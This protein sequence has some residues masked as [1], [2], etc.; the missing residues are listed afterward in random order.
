[1]RQALRAACIVAIVLASG[2][3]RAQLSGSHIKG[4]FG[5]ASGT[6]APEGLLLVPFV[7]DYYTSTVVGMNGNSFSIQGSLDVLAAPGL[8]LWYVSP[9]KVLGANYGAQLSAAFVA[10]SIDLPRVNA[11]TSHYGFG[12]MFLKPVELGWHEKYFDAITGFGIYLPTGSYTPLANNNTGLGQWG[13][14]FQAGGTVW[15]DEGRHFNLA[16]TAF[17]DIFTSK[18]ASLPSPQGTTLRTGNI[19]NSGRWSRLP[20]PGG[21]LQRGHP[22]F[23][24]WKVTQD[25]LPASVLPAQILNQIGSAKDFSAGVGAEVNFFFTQT[26]GIT[27]RWLQGIDGWNTTRG[28]T[29]FFFYNHIFKI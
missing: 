29:F 4:Q 1:M 22:Y 11:K 13:Y 7:Y 27:L 2:A 19:F 24:E 5:L 12:D 28:S 8:F 26:D 20:V 16:T 23:L 14:E 6:Q 9:W 18:T 21:R 15:F 3:A 10:G 17:Y 25:T